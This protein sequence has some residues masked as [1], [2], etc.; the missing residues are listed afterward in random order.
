MPLHPEIKKMLADFKAMQLAEFNT[1]TP[2]E[3]RSRA[4]T[5]ANSRVLPHELPPVEI[6]DYQIPVADGTHILGRLYKPETITTKSLI[7]FYHGGGYVFG[8]VETHDKT[9][10][11]LASALQTPI[12][13]IDYRLAPEYPFPT[14]IEDG[15]TAFEWVVQNATKIGVAYEKLVVAGDSAGGNLATMVSL[16]ARDRYAPKIDLQFLIYPWISDDFDTHSYRQYATDHLLTKKDCIYFTE[17]YMTN[18]GAVDYSAF[19]LENTDLK[20]L[21]P[22]FVVVAECDVLHDEGVAYAQKLRAAGNTVYEVEAE[23]MIHGF[24]NQFPIKASY[25]AVDKIL[26]ELRPLL[27]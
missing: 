2:K 20:N 14:S 12:I 25:N 21:P 26:K 6:S 11:W 17:H 16:L 15:Y 13:S 9:C 27:D 5:M 19:P 8:S 22:A 24:L 1:L 10:R 23:G 18:A 3:V 4:L 7:I